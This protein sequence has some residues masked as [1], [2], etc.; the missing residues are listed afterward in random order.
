MAGPRGL[1]VVRRAAAA[2]VRVAGTGGTAV[3]VVPVV[4]DEGPAE[5][6]AAAAVGGA[7]ATYRYDEFRSADE[8]TAARRTGRSSPTVR[9]TRTRW[10]RARTAAPGWPGRS[11]WPGTWSTNRRVR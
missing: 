3:L 9:P 2:F 1:E 6:A 5:V 7:L 8:P 10:P 11:D 4:E